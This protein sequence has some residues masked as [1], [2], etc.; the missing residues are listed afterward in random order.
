MERKEI[1]N[2]LD[3]E[4]EYQDWKWNTAN[5][6]K[7]TECYMLYM[8]ALLDEAIQKISHTAGDFE[9]LDILRKVVTL[10]IACFEDNG[11]PSR[12]DV[13]KIIAE[14]TNNEDENRGNK[15]MV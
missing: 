14:N 11:V 13:W 8:K 4:R 9:A 5:R 12:G 2:I 1:Y 15:D 3:G 6:K 7:P 10:G